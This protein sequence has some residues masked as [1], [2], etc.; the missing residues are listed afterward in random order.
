M[1]LPSPQPSE[2]AV[3]FTAIRNNNSNDKGGVFMLDTKLLDAMSRMDIEAADRSGLVD[4]TQVKVDT[5]LPAAERMENYLDQ[6]K[7]PY[8]FLCGETRVRVRF[9][10]EG[11]ELKSKLTSFFSTLKTC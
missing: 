3:L 8:C 5:A 1:E 9:K 6:I 2:D 10:P 4:I 7:N 11:Q